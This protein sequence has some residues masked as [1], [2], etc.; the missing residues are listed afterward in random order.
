LTE[1]LK[2]SSKVKFFSCRLGLHNINNGFSFIFEA[3]SFNGINDFFS[4]YLPTVIIVKNI[5]NFF[6]FIDSLKALILVDILRSIE[7]LN[8]IIFYWLGRNAGDFGRH[9]L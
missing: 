9:E 5:K 3:K 1:D 4:R 7:R 6:E 2:E 8:R